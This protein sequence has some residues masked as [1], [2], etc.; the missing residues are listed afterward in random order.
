M[1]NRFNVLPMSEPDT[2]CFKLGPLQYSS[3]IMNIANRHQDNFPAADHCVARGDLRQDLLKSAQ[4]APRRRTGSARQKDFVL[5]IP[6]PTL[7]NAGIRI[8]PIISSGCAR[9][10]DRRSPSPPLPAQPRF[11]RLTCHTIPADAGAAFG[12]GTRFDARCIPRNSSCVLFQNVKPRTAPIIN[13]L[14][15]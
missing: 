8:V 15:D 1:T 12:A 10:F 3:R 7:S 13:A 14:S 2:R 11:D 4:P 5:F 6:G 9:L